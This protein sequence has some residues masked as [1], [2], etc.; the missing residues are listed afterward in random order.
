MGI[1]KEAGKQV[2]NSKIYPKD[3]IS[4]S[5]TAVSKSSFGVI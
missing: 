3:G 1:G 2:S 4:S 5:G